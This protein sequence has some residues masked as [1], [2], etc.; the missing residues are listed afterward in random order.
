MPIEKPVEPQ[1]IAVLLHQQDGRSSIQSFST[2][3]AA[4]RAFDAAVAKG[5]LT[6]AQLLVDGTVTRLFTA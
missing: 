5:N 4:E 1:R 2:L 3:L 6:S